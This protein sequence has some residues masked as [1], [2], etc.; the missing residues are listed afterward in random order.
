MAVFYVKMADPNKT[1]YKK[2]DDEGEMLK[3]WADARF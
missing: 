2:I 1:K 3:A